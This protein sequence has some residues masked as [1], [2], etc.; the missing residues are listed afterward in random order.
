MDVATKEYQTD[1]LMVEPHGPTSPPSV[2]E[3]AVLLEIAPASITSG[4][5]SSQLSL[6]GAVQ[7]A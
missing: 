1:P 2:E 7:G 5:P 6:Q 3:L 4:V